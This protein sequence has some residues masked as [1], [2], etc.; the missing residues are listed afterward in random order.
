MRMLSYVLVEI[1]IAV[2]VVR[3][4]FRWVNRRNPEGQPMNKLQVV[5]TIALTQ[6]LCHA[7]SF[8]GYDRKANAFLIGLLLPSEGRVSSFI[9]SKF[10]YIQMTFVLPLY[11]PMANL[12]FSGRKWDEVAEVHGVRRYG[13]GTAWVNLVY[14]VLVS[15]VGKMSGTLAAAKYFGLHWL[16]AVTLGVLLNTKGYFH[17]FL[18]F[19]CQKNYFM[20]ENS[21]QVMMV[22]G[23]MTIVCAPP[24]ISLI[25]RNVRS[26]GAAIPR[27][28]MGMQWY[29]PAT[30]LRVI[31]GLWGPQNV[32]SAANIIEML[33]G[34]ATTGLFHFSR[35]ENSAPVPVV[36]VSLIISNARSK[37]ATTRRRAEETREASDARMRSEASAAVLNKA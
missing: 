37:G 22:A 21:G 11:F 7:S 20:E 30:A 9:I 5:V 29:N 18:A 27:L 25:I 35:E 32:P 15:A 12:R 16:E 2:F 19:H 3:P 34:G 8:F 23:M 33:R 1:L 17:F 13:K 24:I 31:V 6:V 28:I 4:A 10:N 26:K 14:A 36:V